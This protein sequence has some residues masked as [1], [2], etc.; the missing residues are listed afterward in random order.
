MLGNNV[1]NFEWPLVRKALYKCSPFIYGRT[2]SGRLLDQLSRQFVE[3]S[4]HHIMCVNDGRV[5]TICAGFVLSTGPI[6]TSDQ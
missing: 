6:Q 5:G 3:V 4:F 2:R 1:K